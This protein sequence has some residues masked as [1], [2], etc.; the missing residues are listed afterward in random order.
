[1]TFLSPSLLWFFGAISIPIAIHLLSRLKQNKVEFSTIRFIK[2][3]ETSSIRKVQIQKLIILLLRMLAIICL[4]IMMAQPV[5]SGFMPGWLAAEQDSKLVIVLDNSASMSVEDGERTFLERSKNIAMTLIPLFKDETTITIA[6]TCPPK[7]AFKGRSNDPKIRNSVRSIRPTAS[8]DHIWR[9]V[10]DLLDDET[11]DQPIKECVIFSDMMYPPDTSF[12]YGLDNIDEW[13]FYFVE[14]TPIFDNLGIVNASPVSRIKTLNQLV[15]LDTRVK[16]S[17]SLNKPKIPLELVFNDQRVGQVVSEFAPNKEKEF[18]FQAY[19]AEVG[20]LQGEIILP[21]DD[22]ELDNYWYLSMPIMDQIRCS[23]IGSNAKDISIL[24][25]MLRSIDPENKFLILESRI[26]SD[27][28]RLFLDD[29]DVIVIHDA[30]GITEQGT[31]DID[32]FLKEGGGVIWFQGDYAK[33]QFHDHL[34]TTIGFPEINDLINAGQGFFSTQAISNNSDITNDIQ[35]RNIDKELPEVYKY[36]RVK[37]GSQHKIHW[38]LNNDD[39]LLLEFSKGSGT[40]FYFSTLLDLRW[41]DLP[42]RGM[43]VPLLYRLMILTGTDEVNTAPVLVDEEKWISVEESK[44][45]NKWEVISPSGRTEMIVPEYDREGINVISTNELGIYQVYSNGEKFTSFP[46]R[47][48]YNEYIEKRITQN[49]IEP[50]LNKEQTRWL[51]MQDNFVETFS[52]TRQGKSLWKIFLATAII[53][54]LIETLIGRP[55]PMKMK[56]KEE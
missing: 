33:D 11:I 34:F 52:E 13:K 37:I 3:L 38:G 4:V 47:L 25:M 36:M 43:M 28:N 16:N 26:Q 14:P 46:T 8:H 12:L 55:E 9:A 21:K 1:M 10:N 24:E 23:I 15:K 29:V 40:I 17:G 27:L 31:K 20:I 48:H 6:Q 54:L 53:L 41:N 42:L 56:S 39:P 32:R 51:T 30:K 18:L 19:P 5:T 44:L 45:R 35:V 22:Y 50:L 49:D 7:V 2:E